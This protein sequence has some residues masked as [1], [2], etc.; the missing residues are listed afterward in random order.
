MC[1]VRVIDHPCTHF[2]GSI[3]NV[4]DDY[5]KL[6][7]EERIAMDRTE[8]W[9]CPRKE[10]PTIEHVTVSGAKAAIVTNLD[11]ATKFVNNSLPFGIQ[12]PSAGCAQCH[13]ANKISKMILD[14]K[15][16][17]P[18]KLA[19]IIQDLKE[20]KC[21]GEEIQQT[22][23]EGDKN[24]EQS[25]Q[26][27]VKLIK[28]QDQDGKMLMHDPFLPPEAKAI[29]LLRRRKGETVDTEEANN[30]A[31]EIAELPGDSK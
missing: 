24:Q 7:Y 11:R 14:K 13:Q 6:P 18:Y 12:L 15:F 9:R 23:G 21:K 30:G 10:G 31:D 3:W 27:L 25:V 2:K 28:A 4:C 5:W 17:K 8:Q 19:A 29:L 20:S 26:H 1:R 16:T 22:E